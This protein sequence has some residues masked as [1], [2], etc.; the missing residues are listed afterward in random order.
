LNGELH[1]AASR[2]RSASDAAF[3]KRLSG[4]E[5]ARVDDISG[6]GATELIHHPGHFPFTGA[7][8]GGGN[9]DTRADEATLVELSLL[10]KIT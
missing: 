7:D 1:S 10:F 3:R 8:V 9:I 6:I 4:G 2:L 5:C